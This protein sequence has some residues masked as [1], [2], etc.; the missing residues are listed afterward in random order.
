MMVR[1]I[2]HHVSQADT[3]GIDA[4]CP[5]GPV[6]ISPEHLPRPEELSVKL[7]IN[8]EETDLQVQGA[9]LKAVRRYVYHHQL[10]DV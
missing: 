6:L 3:T 9:S 4:F 1:Y 5:F 2:G 10:Y 8:G 7:V